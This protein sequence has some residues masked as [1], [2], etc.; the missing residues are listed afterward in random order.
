MAMKRTVM[1]RSKYPLTLILM[2][3]VP[4]LLTG[5]AGVGLGEALP[6]V[7]PTPD[8]A[9]GPVTASGFLEVEEVSVVSERDGRVAEVLV[10]EADSVRAGD[11]VVVL[12]DTLLRADR[13]EAEAAVRTAEANLA[14]VKAGATREEIEAAQAAVE[15]ARTA[16]EGARRYSGQAWSAASDP[17]DV[18]VQIASVQVELSQAQAQV[19]ELR[20]QLAEL[21]RQIQVV[22]MVPEGEKID[23]TR[24]DFLQLSREQLV[25][26]IAAAEAGRDGAQRKLDLLNEQRERPVALIA[27][28]ISKQAQIQVAETQLALAEAQLAALTADPLPEEIAI[29]EGQVALAKARVAL[30][31]AQIAQLTLT[32]PVDGTV[33]VRAI[34]PGEMASAGVP[35]LTIAGMDTLKIVVYIPETQIG[36]VRTGAPV[37]VTVDA[38]PGETFRGEVVRIA[39]EAE[40]TPRNVL[41]EEERVNLVFAVE[42]ALPNGDGRLKAGMPADVVIEP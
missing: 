41:T 22:Q 7:Q 15:Q 1:Q 18:A 31:D 34:A 6:Q 12:D 40:F 26:Q 16:V 42:I 25:S 28:A 10:D 35:L 2:V 37:S 14:A 39:S 17:K 21:D 19:D 11:V 5:C 38:Y 8:P 33:T 23:Q 20:A 9:N 30:I 36:R 13:L 4:L 24:L 27:D 3:L 29:A 32:A